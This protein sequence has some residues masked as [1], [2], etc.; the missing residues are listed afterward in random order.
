MKYER[1][2]TVAFSGHRTYDGCCDEALRCA[3]RQHYAQGYRLFLTGM[4]AGFDLAAGEAVLN[5]RNDLPEIA[6]GCVVPF[7]GH[8]ATLPAADRER[9][10]WLMREAALRTTLAVRYTA[11]AYMRRNDYLVTHAEALIA[12]FDGHAGGTAYTITHAAREGLNIRNLWLNPQ[13][14]FDF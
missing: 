13:G 4:A 9:Y 10:E 3:V 14:S 7:A 12:Y 1:S 5:L 8:G 6:L 2:Q 11:D